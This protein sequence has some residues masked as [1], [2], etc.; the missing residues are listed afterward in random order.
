MLELVLTKLAM[1][2]GYFTDSGDGRPSSD[3]FVLF[4]SLY[5]IGEELKRP[6][7]A[8]DKSKSYSY[9]QI[10]EGLQV[11]AKAKEPRAG[12][13]AATALKIAAITSASGRAAGNDTLI[14]LFSSSTRHAIF[15]NRA[16]MVSNVAPYHAD[17]SGA[18]RRSVCSQ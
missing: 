11:L 1:D 14:R 10:R 6:G 12:R 17:F 18:A 15:T 7:R 2:K 5:Q 13:P 8:G 4:T 16:R 3:S 9:A